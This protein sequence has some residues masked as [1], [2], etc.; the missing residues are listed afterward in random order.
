MKHVGREREHS[1]YDDYFV[2]RVVPSNHPLLEID[3]E[4][5][6]SFVRELVEE[7]YSPDTGREAVDPALL[8]RLCFLQSYYNLSDREVISRAQTDLALR[9]FLHL[10]LEDGLPHPTMLTVFR[11]RLG[12]GMFREVFNRSVR[13]AVERGLVSGRLVMVDSFGI[14]ADVAIPRLR[15]LLMRV[16]RRG[17]L[18]MEALGMDTTELGREREALMADDSWVQSKDLRERDLGAWFGLTQRVHDA[19]VGAQVRPEDESA[20]RAVVGLLSRAL[21]RQQA[22]KRGQRREALVSDVDP[23]ARWSARERGKK[24]FV[25]YKQQIAVD[26]GSQIITAAQVTAGNVDDTEA[27]EGLVEGHEQNT[28]RAPEGVAADSGYSSGANRRKLKRKGIGDYIAAPKP[29]GHKQGRFSASDFEPE[30]DADGVARRVRCPAGQVAQGG[31][32]DQQEAGWTFYFT[33]GQ[34]TGCALRDKCTKAKRGRAVFVSGYFLEHQQARARQ[35]E[36]DF[37][38]AQVARLGIERTFAYQQRRSG[39]ARA[40]YRG[41]G[42]VAIQ[43]L[44]SCFV[45]NAVRIARASRRAATDAYNPA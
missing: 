3:R 45:V 39:H 15:K 38:A 22:H 24:A 26:E 5:D 13:Q 23:D 34:C 12:E 30:F 2:R 8:L 10:G 31:K 28:G 35:Q 6:F 25:G 17:L 1:L 36:A 33:R 20:R 29:K 7:L 27:L 11:R 16:V 9:V 32:W 41:L 4:V 14:V 18:A 43:V 40:R 37:V 44:L 21:Q 19:L 42:R